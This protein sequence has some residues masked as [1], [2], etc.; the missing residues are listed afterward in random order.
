MRG[1]QCRRNG[2]ARGDCPPRTR[3]EPEL[4]SLSRNPQTDR[5]PLFSNLASMSSPS[6]PTGSRILNLQRSQSLD[7][8]TTHTLNEF[9]CQARTSLYTRKDTASL[10]MSGRHAKEGPRRSYAKGSPSGVRPTPVGAH[11]TH[12]FE[13]YRYAERISGDPAGPISARIRRVT[14]NRRVEQRKHLQSGFDSP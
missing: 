13:P 2:L 14:S 3:R 9:C 8:E 5:R 6:P 4:P 7:P 10:S 11:R 1:S 12:R